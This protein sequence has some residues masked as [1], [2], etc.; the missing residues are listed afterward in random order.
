VPAEL[1]Q[2]IFE[3][4]FTTNPVGEGTGLGLDICYRVIAQRH[5]GDLRVVSVLR[6]TRFRVRLPINAPS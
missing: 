4:F 3:P 6:D 5:G 1:Q 2:K